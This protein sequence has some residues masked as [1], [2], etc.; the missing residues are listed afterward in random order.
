MKLTG[1][2]I[3]LTY[4]CNLECDHC[5]V[6][7]GQWQEG[8]LTLHQIRDIL[9]QAKDL[10]MVSSIYFEG[11]EPFLYYPTMLKGVQE[12]VAMGFSAGLVSNGY[13]GTS[14][15][16]AFEWLQPF[17]GLIQDLSI[18]LDA[19]HWIE[20]FGEY[21]ENIQKVAEELAIPM[22]VISVAQPETIDAAKAVGQLPPGES[23]VMY[24]GRAAVNLAPRSEK[25]PWEEFTECPYENLVDPGRIHLDPLGNLHICQGIVIGNLF[26]TPLSEIATSYDHTTHPITAPLLEEG[27][28]G[29]VKRYD[30]PHEEAYADACHLCYSARLALRDRFPDVLGPDQMYGV[31]N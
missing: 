5:F 3:L 11:G 6:F 31:E 30:L 4:Q 16:D 8:T 24:R 10:G 7:G 20:R 17:K 26:E 13:W 22:G 18:S 23:E 9:Q 12:A 21:V 1:L 25:H 2:H 28:V 27:P 29:L 14:E 19:Y 15:A